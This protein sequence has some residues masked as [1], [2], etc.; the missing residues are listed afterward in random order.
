M[1]PKAME[2]VRCYMASILPFLRERLVAHA[3]LEV[4]GKVTHNG[5]F[6]TGKFDAICSLGTDDELMLVDWKTVSSAS[7]KADTA[8]DETELYGSPCSWRRTW[9]P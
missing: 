9:A 3:P 8:A 2:S 6:Y 1:E 4:E 7:V 5:L